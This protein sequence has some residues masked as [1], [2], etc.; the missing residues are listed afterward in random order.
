V[1]ATH[2]QPPQVR[3]AA[4]RDPELRAPAARVAPPGHEAEVGR[5]V[6]AAREASGMLEREHVGE[7]GER[8]DASDLAQR[9]R[10]GIVRRA[11]RLDLAVGGGDARAELADQLEQR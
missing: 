9:F 5:D 8:A 4:L 1:R 10:L 11:E 2:E 6:A 7:R 3:V